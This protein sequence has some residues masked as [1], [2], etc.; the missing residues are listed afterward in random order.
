MTISTPPRWLPLNALRAFE[1]AARHLSFAQAAHELGVTPA[2]V[3]QQ[4]KRLEQRLGQPLFLRLNRAVRLTEAGQRL[5]APLGMLFLQMSDL[6]ETAVQTLPMLEVTAMP[7]LATKWLA[8]RLARFNTV[9][10]DYQ[11]RVSGS[12]LLVDFNRQPVDVG[13]RYGRGD[14]GELFSEKLADVSAFPVCSPAFADAYREK[15]EGPNGL[16]AVPLIHDESS[17]VDSGLPTWPRW[18]TAAG[19]P[20]TQIR[21]ILVFESIH[22]AL[23]AA[24]AGQG[25][26]LGMSLLVDDDLRQG[27]LVR[28]SD[29][30]LKS[31]F[32]YWL[33][34]RRD[35]AE[36]KGV[37]AF[38]DWLKSELAHPSE[39]PGVPTPR[40]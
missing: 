1:A 3:S 36:L 31:A 24:L 15:L 37:R 2:A 19:L 16:A 40:P 7:S 38:R 32:S 9:C 18:F 20:A 8:P 10:P 13:L 4:V 17:I 29:V 35:K 39:V 28:L 11:V 25:V 22:M 5:A 33:V 23:D 27:R 14:Y 6:V 34:C 30:E 12:D 26:A 21:R